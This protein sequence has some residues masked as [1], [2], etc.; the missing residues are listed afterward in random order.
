MLPTDSD[1]TTDS[2]TSITDQELAI[3]LVEMK[4]KLN[5][6]VSLLQSQIT[7]TVTLLDIYVQKCEQQQQQ[8]DNLKQ[9]LLANHASFLKLFND[10]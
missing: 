5:F 7:E 10:K 3:K 9:Q 1:T 8:N 6:T 4:N 2:D